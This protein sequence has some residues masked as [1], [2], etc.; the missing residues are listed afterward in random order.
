VT[1]AGARRLG[2]DEKAEQDQIACPRRH[3]SA[4]CSAAPTTVGTPKGIPSPPA[5]GTIPE[6]R[7]LVGGAGG[8]LQLRWKQCSGAQVLWRMRGSAGRVC[9]ELERCEHTQ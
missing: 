4:G 9:L 8:L 7:A 3:G 1:A 2:V 5:V 6:R